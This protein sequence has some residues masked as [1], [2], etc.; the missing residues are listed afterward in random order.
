MRARELKHL[1]NRDKARFNV[2]YSVNNQ[3]PACTHAG[4]LFA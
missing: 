2:L 3:L 4:L 1:V